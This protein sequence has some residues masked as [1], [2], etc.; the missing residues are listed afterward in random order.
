MSQAWKQLE[1]RVARALG[2][3]RVLGNR[4]RASGSDCD[5][6]VPFSVELKH[7]FQRYQLRGDWIEQARR[8]ARKEGRPWLLVQSL[9]GSQR[10]IVTTDF[11]L[12]A[13]LAQRA[14]LI[15]TVEVSEEE[16]KE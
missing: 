13:E 6:R 3:R 5:E 16:G 10:P 14:G 1:D 11:W 15:G 8:N 4:G 2:G 7:G 9:K 12:F